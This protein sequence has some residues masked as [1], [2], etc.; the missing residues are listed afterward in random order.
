MVSPIGIPMEKQI[1][2]CMKSVGL[3][4]LLLNQ[5]VVGQKLPSLS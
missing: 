3:D 5:L 1:E 2:R 4:F